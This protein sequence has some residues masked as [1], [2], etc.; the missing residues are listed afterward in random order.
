M[1]KYQVATDADGNGNLVGLVSY[2]VYIKP[3]TK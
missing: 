2:I 3:S 1:I